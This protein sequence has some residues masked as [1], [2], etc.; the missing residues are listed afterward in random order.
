MRLF[1]PHVWRT[2]SVHLGFPVIDYTWAKSFLSPPIDEET[3]RALMYS[4]RQLEQLAAHTT[5]KCSPFS[6]SRRHG[7]VFLSGK[8]DMEAPVISREV[9]VEVPPV[10]FPDTELFY[11]TYSSSLRFSLTSR[12]LRDRGHPVLSDDPEEEDW[13]PWEVIPLLH[14]SSESFS[15]STSI[16]LRV[17]QA[18][19]FS[20]S[21]NQDSGIP[22]PVHYLSPNARSPAFLPLDCELIA[23]T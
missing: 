10:Q 5:N 19:H 16:P 2:I 4:R 9:T 17:V 20:D 1:Q 15:A 14:N 11:V 7:E 12:S 21:A 18:T 6:P 8:R 13:V 3:E 22:P 23:S